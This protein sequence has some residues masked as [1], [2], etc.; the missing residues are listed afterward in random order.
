MIY[1]AQMTGE[2]LPGFTERSGKLPW[3]GESS[4]GTLSAVCSCPYAWSPCKHSVAAVLAH[5]WIAS[6]TS[7]MFRRS[8]R[9]T[10]GLKLIEDHSS[11]E[12]VG[13]FRETFTVI[14]Y[15][16]PGAGKSSVYPICNG[17][18]YSSAGE[19]RTT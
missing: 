19:F 3:P 18:D 4:S 17:T 9:A 10:G 1:V 14:N 13:D 6:R 11:Q 7:K 12:I 15:S 5:P 2:F 16:L 8:R